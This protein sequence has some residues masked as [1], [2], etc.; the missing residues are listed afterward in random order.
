MFAWVSAYREGGTEALRAKPAPGQPRKLSG[1]QV[2]RLYTLITGANLRQ[3]QF[4]FDL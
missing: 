2:R 3:L 4:E 1:A